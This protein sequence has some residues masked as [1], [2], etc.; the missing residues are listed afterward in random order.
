MKD[1]VYK[2]GPGQLQLPVRQRGELATGL[3]KL[4]RTIVPRRPSP[5]SP[6]PNP[7]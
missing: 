6:P 1:A 7:A 2:E 4:L 5:S 3:V